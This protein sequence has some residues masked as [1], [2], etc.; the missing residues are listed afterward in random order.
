MP[1]IRQKSITMRIGLF[2][3]QYYPSISGVVTSIRMLYDGLV[4][5]GH[6]VFI[7]TSFDEEMVD[8]PDEIT[9][10]NV[11][12]IP[13]KSYPFKDLKEYRFSFKHRKYIKLVAPYKLDVIH[14]HTEFSVAKI[15]R[16][17]GKKLGIPIIHT[18]HTLYEDYIK[19]ISEFADKYFHDVIFSTLAKMVIEPV[20]KD[21]II[22]IVPTKKVLALVERYYMQ[23]DIRVVPTGIQLGRFN[24]SNYT[25]EEINHL[26]KYL[27]I[28]ENDFVYGYLGRTSGEKNI[29]T[30]IKAFS[31]ISNKENTVLLIVGG[32]PELDELQEFANSLG[33]LEYTRFT[34]LVP[35]DQAPMYYQV[36]DIFVNASKSETQGLTYIEA[37]ASG[38]PLLV[39]RDDCIDDVVQDYYNG[40]YF[41]GEEE[42]VQ[43]ME[44]IQKVPTTLKQI[45][46]NTELSVQK[47]SKEQYAK[48]IEAVYHDAIDIYKHGRKKK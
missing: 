20:S 15:G 13:G 24:K 26:R 32:G 14:I 35:W 3:D 28:N 39:Q 38:L 11:I 36:M 37:L 48:N 7:F 42:L 25:L 44:E 45:K 18:L 8:N 9:K 40:I 33:V 1:N 41:D 21:S 5:L 23:G 10:R 2:T 4:S 12:N 17:S 46:A 47:Y 6:E 31:K 22:E 34:G 19:Y 30:I 27:K 29:K 16:V 43:K